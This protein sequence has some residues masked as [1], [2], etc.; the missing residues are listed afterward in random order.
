MD[1]NVSLQRRSTAAIS[2]RR[3]VTN[4]TIGARTVRWPTERRRSLQPV[5]PQLRLDKRGSRNLRGNRSV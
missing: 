2:R 1:D 4:T 5:C 3:G